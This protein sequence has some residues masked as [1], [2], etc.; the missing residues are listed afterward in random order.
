MKKYIVDAK[1]MQ[2]LSIRFIKNTYLQIFKHFCLACFEGDNFSDEKFSGLMF[3]FAEELSN[4]NEKALLCI[5]IEND[6]IEKI[7]SETLKEHE[8]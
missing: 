1:Q 6:K 2:D 4:N 5:T 8:V 7:L 3:S